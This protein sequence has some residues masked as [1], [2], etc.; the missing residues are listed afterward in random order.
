MCYFYHIKD[1]ECL[2]EDLFRPM[3]RQLKCTGNVMEVANEVKLREEQDKGEDGEE[4][5]A[6]T[7]EAMEK[8]DKLTLELSLAFI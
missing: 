2:R 6:G 4:G 3:E 7:E 1:G 8:L 5:R